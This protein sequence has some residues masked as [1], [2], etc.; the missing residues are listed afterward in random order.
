MKILA[1]IVPLLLLSCQACTAEYRLAGRDFECEN[2]T[3]KN[4]MSCCLQGM[5]GSKSSAS[6]DVI[7]KAV[8]DELSQQLAQDRRAKLFKQCFELKPG[9]KL[10]VPLVNK[11]QAC[12]DKIN[13]IK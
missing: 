11:N 3:A 1:L 8:V 5:G 4:A 10:T 7:C 9:V 13:G 12:F 2:L 6:K